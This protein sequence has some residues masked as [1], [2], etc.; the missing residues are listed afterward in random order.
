MGALVM[1]PLWLARKEPY[2]LLHT[3][4]HDKV[5]MFFLGSVYRTR[6]REEKGGLLRSEPSKGSPLRNHLIYSFFQRP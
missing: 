3:I 2:F 5:P 1:N 4:G 6:G